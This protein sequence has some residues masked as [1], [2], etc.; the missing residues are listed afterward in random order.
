MSG[1]FPGCLETWKPEKLL[2]FQE[3]PGLSGNMPVLKDIR[4]VWKLSRLSGNLPDFLEDIQ[5][6]WKLSS[7]SQNLPD[8]WKISRSS[9]NVPAI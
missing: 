2:T 4:D 5:V 8:F 1:N 3:L 7:L 6:L 9:G